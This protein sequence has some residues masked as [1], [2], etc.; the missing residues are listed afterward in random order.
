MRRHEISDEN[1]HRIESLLPGRPGD[2]G[3]TA[4]D[5]RSFINAVFWIAKTGAPWRDLPSRFG[6]WNSVFK[7]F[8]RWSKKGVWQRVA[9]ALGGD[10]DL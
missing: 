6:K 4:A 7:R 2:P 5:N 3:V 10:A 9:E 1:W 8:D